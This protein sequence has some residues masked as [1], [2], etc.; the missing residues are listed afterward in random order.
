MKQIIPTRV[1]EI[2]Y[3][4]TIA[5]F[6]VLHIKTAGILQVQKNVPSYMPGNPSMWVYITGVAFL[7]IAIAIII[8]KYKRLACYGLVALLVLFFFMVHLPDLMINKYNLYQP[9]KDIAMAM[10]AIMIGNN[11]T[12]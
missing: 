10:A 12:K 9:L 5:V 8:N 4:L 2:I 6:G 1:A 7:L 11:A 3:A